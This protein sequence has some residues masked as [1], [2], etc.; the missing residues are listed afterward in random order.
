MGVKCETTFQ[1]DFEEFDESQ[2]KAITD[3][4][5]TT[6]SS[7]NMITASNHIVHHGYHY[8]CRKRQCAIVLSVD[9]IENNPICWLVDAILYIKGEW[10]LLLQ[11]LLAS[12]EPHFKSYIV[13][14]SPVYICGRPVSPLHPRLETFILGGFLA[15]SLKHSV[16]NCAT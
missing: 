16:K 13:K 1:L 9:D 5:P 2:R 8:F 7:A 15:V 10:I 4:F 3:Y 6:I 14:R 11:K 12:Y